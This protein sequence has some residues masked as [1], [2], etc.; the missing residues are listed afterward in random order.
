MKVLRGKRRI[1]DKV[2][3]DSRQR[4]LPRVYL[5]ILLLRMA[6]LIRQINTSDIQ[7]ETV[8]DSLPDDSY[9]KLHFDKQDVSILPEKKVKYR[10]TQYSIAI[11]YIS[12]QRKYIILAIETI[13]IFYDF[14]NIG[15]QIIGFSKRTS[16]SL[17]FSLLKYKE[18]LQ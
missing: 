13:D 10:P 5:A 14:S 6:E 12:Q 15:Y 11:K 7:L 9:S 8:L 1:Q 17:Q 2:G 3:R 16:A 4:V 18:I